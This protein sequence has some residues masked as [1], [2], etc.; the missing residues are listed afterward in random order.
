MGAG[1]VDRSNAAARI[2]NSI[3]SLYQVSVNQTL[4]TE[5]LL[6]AFSNQFS[7]LASQPLSP[8]AQLYWNQ[9]LQDTRFL[10]R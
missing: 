7:M 1:P 10:N 4:V 3:Q 9:Q 5:Q 2:V 8:E 6:R